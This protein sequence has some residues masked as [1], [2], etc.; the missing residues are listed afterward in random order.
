MAT[1]PNCNTN[2]PD[3]AAHCPNCGAALSAQPPAQPPVYQQPVYQQP[4][5]QQPPMPQVAYQQPYGT[6]P[7]G[8]LSTGMLVWSII[9]IFLCTVLGVIALVFTV[10]AKGSPNGEDEQSKLKTAKI[11]NIIATIGGV[12]SIIITIIY[13]VV[14]FAAVGGIASELGGYYY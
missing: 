13:V 4:A 7:S 14:V 9:N 5:Y 11:L 10:M 8:Q 3:N 1:C 12:L 6:P 2:V